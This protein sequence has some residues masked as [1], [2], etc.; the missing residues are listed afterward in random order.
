[1]SEQLQSSETVYFTRST[2]EGIKARPKNYH[3]RKGCRHIRVRPN[4][5]SGTLES[6][7]LKNLKPCPHCILGERPDRSGKVETCPVCDKEV[8]NLGNHLRRGHC[9][10]I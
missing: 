8:L 10:S 9:D 1:M 7:K 2:E 6:A 4:V 3:K 5:R